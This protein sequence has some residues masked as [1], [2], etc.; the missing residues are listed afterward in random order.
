M[1]CGGHNPLRLQP[2]SFVGLNYN[3]L[4]LYTKFLQSTLHHDPSDRTCGFRSIS[5]VGY[6]S[7]VINHDLCCV[8]HRRVEIPMPLLL[9]PNVGAPTSCGGCLDLMRLDALCPVQKAIVSHASTTPQ[10]KRRPVTVHVQHW[11]MRVWTIF[12]NAIL[13]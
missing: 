5:D 6:H 11:R 7:T 4:E 9:Y 3:Y 2:A 13:S 1:A 12:S 8:Q 10:P